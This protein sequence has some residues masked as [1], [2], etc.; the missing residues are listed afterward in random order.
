[1]GQI[2]KLFPKHPQGSL[3]SN[4]EANP[5]ERLKAITLQS[6]KEVGMGN[7]RV[8]EKEKRPEIE[9]VESPAREEETTPIIMKRTPPLVK[10]YA[11]ASLTHQD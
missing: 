4:T 3:Q 5:S 10:E 9:I 1:M 11:L 6:G 8:T 7:E 2:A